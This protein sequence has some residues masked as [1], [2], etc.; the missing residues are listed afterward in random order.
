MN[1]LVSIVMPCFNAAEHVRAT[2]RSAL[3]QSHAN[4]ELICVD[5]GS[6]DGTRELLA[7]V[8]DPRV[9]VIEQRNAGSGAARN[10]GLASAT[11]S[12]IAFLDA[13]DTWEPT[14]LEKLLGAL[15]R[16]PTAGLAYCGW[17]NIHPGGTNGIPYLPPD[18]EAGNK[19]EH[20]LTAC[21]WPIHAAL[22]R[23]SVIRESGFFDPTL[24]SCMDY[25]LWLRIASRNKIVRVPEVLAYYIH[26]AGVRITHDRSLVAVNNWR[27]QRRFVR[28]NLQAV[29]SL[30]RRHIRK[31]LEGELL[32]TGYQCYW[33]RDLDAARIIFRQ[34]MATGYGS[35]KDWLYMLPALL[36]RALHERLIALFSSHP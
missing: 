3:E 1:S 18:Y 33:R 15:Q 25:D 27:V 10:H 5:E 34:V 35:P 23:A 26:H 22:V 14:F 21:P 29:L 16:C 31:L 19:I 28:S 20:L 9:R 6:T 13:D 32:Y 24:S 30:K 4:L 12:F 17:Q 2:V 8:Q 7:A 11:G 36:P